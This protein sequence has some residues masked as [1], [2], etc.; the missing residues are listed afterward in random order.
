MS[1]QAVIER[2]DAIEGFL[3]RIM[4]RLDQSSAPVARMTMPEVAEKL[5][6]SVRTVERLCARCVFSDA[7]GKQDRRHGCKRMLFS[8]EVQVYILEG[9]P[10]VK[11]F[12]KELGRL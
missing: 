7:R 2:L 5:R 9:A 4:K 12:R 11:R 3:V 8:D 6:V 10:A 1:D